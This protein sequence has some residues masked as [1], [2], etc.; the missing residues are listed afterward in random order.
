MEQRR[1]N[2]RVWPA[3]KTRSNRMKSPAH[4]DGD[5]R[6]VELLTSFCPVVS[7]TTLA[8]NEVVR[9]E[10][11][12]E[13]TRPHG[14]HGSGLKINQDRTRNVFVRADFIVVYV[15]ALELK[16]VIALVQALA[17]DAVFV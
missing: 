2:Y 9:S 5:E 13:G 17:V 10:Q 11:T 6:N 16:V 1:G 8:E 3:I 7:C 15:D 4:I 14:V 12:T